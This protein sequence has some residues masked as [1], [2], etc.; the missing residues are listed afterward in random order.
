M[1]RI[2]SKK[3]EKFVSELFLKYKKEND[4]KSKFKII[5][6]IANFYLPYLERVSRNISK[7]YNYNYKSLISSGYFGLTRA[8][9]SY[10]YEKNIS[11]G[12][13]ISNYV[14]NYIY[15][16][17][18]IGKYKI[19]GRI[20]MDNISIVLK[21]IKEVELVYEKE[22]N[23]NN[24]EM[25]NYFIDYLEKHDAIDKTNKEDMLSALQICKA[26]S[27]DELIYDKNGNLIL[28]I[29][30]NSVSNLDNM[31]LVETLI[32]EKYLTELERKIL[33][34]RLN[35]K[36]CESISKEMNK[37]KAYINKMELKAYLKLKS[38]IK[39]DEIN[40]DSSFNDDFLKSH[41]LI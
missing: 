38:K 16:E 33:I 21:A 2:L 12:S 39:K 32:N 29:E 26:S 35:G 14:S 13:N 15:R 10:E 30:S 37:S 34:E 6:E 8:I 18:I 24:K 5:N 3:K 19:N 25:V 36:T 20:L 9:E 41:K 1:S 4:E 40:Y 7:K 17:L 23:V 22:F 31:L 11:F 27:L 28:D